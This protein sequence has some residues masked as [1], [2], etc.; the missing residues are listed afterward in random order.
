MSVL[1]WI[2]LMIVWIISLTKWDGKCHCNLENCKRCPYNGA[3]EWQ[4]G[5]RR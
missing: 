3:C 2:I 4:K 1:L 5:D